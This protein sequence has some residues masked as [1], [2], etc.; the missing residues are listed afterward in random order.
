MYFMI[1]SII[2]ISLIGTLSHFLYDIS[3]HNKLV[4]LFCAVNEST[5]EHIKISLTPCLL[6][7][8]LDGFIYG[9]NPN[10]FWL[11]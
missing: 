1:A 6:W 4:G 10:Y 5:W 7:G 11:S 3:K 2:A 8:V 9:T